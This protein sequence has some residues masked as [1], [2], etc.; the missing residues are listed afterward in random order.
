MGDILISSG[1][2]YVGMNKIVIINGPNLNL[3]GQREQEVFGSQTFDEE[4]A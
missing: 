4:V 1:G 3:Q 2:R